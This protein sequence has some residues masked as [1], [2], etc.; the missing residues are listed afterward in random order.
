MTLSAAADIVFFSE[1]GKSISIKD[2]K[3]NSHPVGCP[4][5][6]LAESF[7]SKTHEKP[8]PVDMIILQ[9]AVCYT[10]EKAD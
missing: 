4:P 5:N 1:V 10:P 8:V 2:G 7:F 3:P 9:S 6:G